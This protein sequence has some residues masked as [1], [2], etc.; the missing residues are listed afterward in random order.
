M[1]ERLDRSQ[2]YPLVLLNGSKIVACGTADVPPTKGV[3]SPDYSL[4]EVT[5]HGQPGETELNSTPTV[6]F[7]YDYTETGH[8]LALD[9]ATSLTTVA[10]SRSAGRRGRCQAQAWQSRWLNDVGGSNVGTLGG[11]RE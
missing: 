6:V 1:F 7:E 5:D 9:A 10:E 2:S 3:K 4:Y 11:G 8:K